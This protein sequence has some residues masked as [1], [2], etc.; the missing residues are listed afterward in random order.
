MLG[1][2][3]D[4]TSRRNIHHHRRNGILEMDCEHEH[5]YDD[6]QSEP[7]KGH[8]YYYCPK[9]KGSWVLNEDEQ[10]VEMEY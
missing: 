8:D 3:L 2:N 4:E 1:R 10:L 5:T 6:Q 9:C 7:H